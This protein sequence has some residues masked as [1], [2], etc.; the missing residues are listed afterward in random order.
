MDKDWKEFYSDPTRRV[1]REWYE[2]KFNYND[3]MLMQKMIVD[4]IER[5]EEISE[6]RGEIRVR[7][8][9]IE[10]LLVQLRPRIA[11]PN[12]GSYD[13]NKDKERS[14]YVKK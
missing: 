6:L 4:I 1:I 7:D 13:S 11:Y 14:I 12:G 3:P 2:S 8:K 9:T 5:D 10:E